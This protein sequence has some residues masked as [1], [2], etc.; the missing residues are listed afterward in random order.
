MK[1]TI[2]YLS[3]HNQALMS[4]QHI[5][6]HLKKNDPILG[7]IID[8]VG[9]PILEPSMPIFHDL[10]SCVLEQQIHYRS[11]KKTFQKMLDLAS[12]KELT[13]NNFHLLEEKSF[14]NVRLSHKKYET[15]NEVI[16]FFENNTINWPSLSNAEIHTLLGEIKG[17]GAKTIDALLIYT[18]KREDVFIYDD[19]HIQKIIPSLYGLNVDGKLTSR[20]KEIAQNW[21]PYQSYA[22]RY[23]LAWNANQ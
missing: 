3:D 16:D 5:K 18:L 2:Y 4:I 11:T 8:S 7:R 15:L 10:M 9:V 12:I 22:F 23:F 1:T 14:A 19:Y 6:E 20:I 13:L 21:K 17:V